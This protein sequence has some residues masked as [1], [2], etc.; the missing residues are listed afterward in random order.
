M[1]SSVPLFAAVSVLAMLFV[2]RNTKTAAPI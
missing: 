2:T 1:V